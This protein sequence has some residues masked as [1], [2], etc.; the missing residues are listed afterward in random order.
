MNALEAGI[1]RIE[2]LDFAE[3]N[4]G[5]LAQDWVDIIDLVW[6][7][8]RQR[9]ESLSPKSVSKERETDG[10]RLLRDRLEEKRVEVGQAMAKG[11]SISI[12]IM[13]HEHLLLEEILTG[14]FPLDGG[15]EQELMEAERILLNYTNSYDYQSRFIERVRRQGERVK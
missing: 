12:P 15:S 6:E 8:D 7:A 3:R 14:N 9:L 11:G 13:P 1:I 2:E 5:L 4:V 10:I